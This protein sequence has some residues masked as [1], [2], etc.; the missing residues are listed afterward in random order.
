MWI[1]SVYLI[2]PA[3][4][5]KE[6]TY[7]SAE[8]HEPG[9]IVKLS[10]RGRSSCGLV[11]ICESVK[12]ARQEVRAAGFS[13]QKITS[14][15]KNI[16][17]KAFLHAVFE[18][19]AYHGTS[20]GAVLSAYV[21]AAIFN[22]LT[23]VREAAFGRIVGKPKE[24]ILVILHRKERSVVYRDIAYQNSEKSKST[25]IIAP[26]IVEAERLAENL[27]RAI[28]MHSELG[29]KKMLEVWNTVV[30]SVN[31]VVIVGTPLAL[32][33]PRSDW[34]SIILERPLARGYER[35]SR[36]FIAVRAMAEALARALGVELVIGSPLLPVEDSAGGGHRVSK[37]KSGTRYPPPASV[38]DMRPSPAVSGELLT[39]KPKFE[40][41]SPQAIARVS[42]TLERGKNVLLITA[43]R[44]LVPHTTCDDCGTPL[45]CP[46]CSSGLVLHE[47][48]QS[49]HLSLVGAR[50]MRWFECHYCGFTE[51]VNI[52]CPICGSWR[53]SMHGIG[54]V[55]VAREAE[56][57]R[58]KTRVL[59]ADDDTAS[60]PGA[61]K[62]LATQFAQSKGA[63]LVATES[64]LAYLETAPLTIVVSAD[65]MLYVPE[66]SAPERALAFL[67]ELHGL[68][69]E[70]I[71]QTRVPENPV[72]KQLGR[73]GLALPTQFYEQELQLR[74]KFQYPPYT[75]LIRL[76]VSGTPPREKAQ[77]DAIV[78][79]LEPFAP[80]RFP[81][82]T[83]RGGTV[84]EHILL[85][86]PK[87]AWIDQKLLAFIRAL[88]PS[89]EVRINP[90]NILSD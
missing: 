35:S 24:P 45:S 60:R 26:T 6:L 89:V 29:K 36:P 80:F 74:K 87:D 82:R 72:I 46:R 12:N 11:A 78:K 28:L 48:Q 42:Q 63:I 52:L 51:K 77:A 58:L 15:G 62:K 70:L 47:K 64:M 73:E 68:S 83:K 21:P 71:V 1:V 88:P 38:I 65:S 81:A 27:P 3:A 59:V 84:R 85:R 44:G 17:T 13:L 69:D 53:L 39:A 8:K 23:S 32:S 67:Y 14:E 37:P 33:L 22:A 54:V 43:R 41:F 56:K 61:A 31:S 86:L 18:V 10:V 9:E 16:F 75:V 4:Q 90:K 19:A 57:L 34:G 7:F 55:L 5:H 79:A 49:A 2:E 25:L 76:S 40:I 20:G 66:Y 50:I 30:S